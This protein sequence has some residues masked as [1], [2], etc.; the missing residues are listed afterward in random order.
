M[1]KRVPR[2]N[3]WIREVAPWVV[4]GVAAMLATYLMSG[5]GTAVSGG[6]LTPSVP[7]VDP[8]GSAPAFTLPDINGKV[9]SLSD[10]EGKV[11]ILDFWATWCPP[12]KREIPDFIDLQKQFGSKGVQVVGIGL[13]EPGKL[14]AFARQYG[15]NYPVLVGNQEIAANYG[16]IEG[17]PTT[18]IIDRSG[19]IVSSFVGYRPAQVFVDEVKKLL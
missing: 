2:H 16:G 3:K 5:K 18:F 17:I 19:K 10:Y 6:E 15:M 13:D 11:V 7:A 9:S 14:A 1:V 12:C 8:A 4:L